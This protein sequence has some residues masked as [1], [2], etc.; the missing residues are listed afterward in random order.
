MF[1][2]DTLLFLMFLVIR[3]FNILIGQFGVS[4]ENDALC[5]TSSSRL[6]GAAGWLGA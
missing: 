2:W 6:G 5:W 3:I 4:D 1:I